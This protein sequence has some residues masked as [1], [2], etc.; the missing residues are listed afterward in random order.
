MPPCKL[1]GEILVRTVLI[2]WNIWK[3][4]VNGFRFEG[5]NSGSGCVCSIS[6]ADR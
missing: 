1:A 2:E 3:N 6:S 5:I 4:N